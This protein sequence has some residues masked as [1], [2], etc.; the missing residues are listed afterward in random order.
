MPVLDWAVVDVAASPC[1]SDRSVA[2]GS[3]GIGEEVVAVAGACD[4]GEAELG[5]C[6]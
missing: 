4:Q 6:A 1:V 2:I 5:C 3:S